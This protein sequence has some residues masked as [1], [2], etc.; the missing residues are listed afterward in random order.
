MNENTL[1]A[2][3]ERIK[4]AV[5]D[6]R[7]TVNK[8]TEA[9]EEVA[10]AV[11][12]L[13]N[14]DVYNVKTFAEMQAISNP[15]DGAI[16]H[17][18]NPKL[19]NLSAGEQTNTL[20]FPKTVV[21]DVALSTEIDEKVKIIGKGSDNSIQ[22]EDTSEITLQATESC[23][24]YTWSMYMSLGLKMNNGYCEYRVG[25]NSID[26]KHFALGDGACKAQMKSGSSTHERY[27]YS[28]NDDVTLYLPFMVY[29]EEEQ[30]YTHANLDKFIY[31]FDSSPLAEGEY[32][33][34]LVFKN[35]IVLSEPMTINNTYAAA[36]VPSYIS[37]D[38]ISASNY[39]NTLNGLHIRLE[40]SSGYTEF[41]V[42]G[43]LDK[44]LGFDYYE[45]NY[46]TPYIDYKTIDGIT[47]N[48]IADGVLYD[49]RTSAHTYISPLASPGQY[50]STSGTLVISLGT[51]VCIRRFTATSGEYEFDNRL[52]N[53][54]RTQNNYNTYTYKYSSELNKWLFVYV[55]D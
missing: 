20:I 14:L 17:I 39:I 13:K 11:A 48:K 44:I 42:D 43:E 38:S 2:N 12:G 46:G 21:F 54:L 29:I 36:L 47:W 37:L 25:Y 23:G 33:S 8:P 40:P 49:F 34:S 6:I 24:N 52:L 4:D 15:K 9:I 19:I 45:F 31:T 41:K 7:T 16:C 55:N 10:E 22:T 30:S 18:Y 1:S 50:D 26:G 51:P 3:L 35:E 28:I 5:D 27:N 53:F 32:T